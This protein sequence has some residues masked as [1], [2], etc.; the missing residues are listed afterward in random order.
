[1]CGRYYID[2]RTGEEI[3]RIVEDAAA[4]NAEGR[5]CRAEMTEAREVFR[6]GDICP[7]QS[8]AVLC[9]HGN[10]LE[11]EN[12]KWGFPGFSKGS[13]LINARAESALEKKTYRDSVLHRRC[14]IPAKG[15]YEWNASKEKFAFEDPDAGLLFMAGC[16]NWF[17]DG[18]HFV[19]LTTEAKGTAARVHERMPL[20]L[21]REEIEA[22]VLDERETE[23]ILHRETEKDLVCGTEYEQM[24]LF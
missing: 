21:D 7:S 11:V 17:E 13:L 1:M 18:D 24:S 8:A 2:E 4:G 12:M 19:I 9:A 22:W 6:A 20:M 14:V 23:K 15:F 5:I 3:G 10:H 16:F